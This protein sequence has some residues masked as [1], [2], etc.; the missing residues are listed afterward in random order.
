MAVRPI[1]SFCCGC[2]LAVGVWLIII[3]NTV[4]NIFYIY[5]AT[6]NIILR[7]PTMGAQQ[8]L[9]SQ[10]W[11]AAWC[12]LGIPFIF[13]G[14]WGL[15]CKQESTL[16]LYLYYLVLSFILDITFCITFFSTTD[17]CADMPVPLRQ[18]GMAFACGFMRLLSL[19]FILGMI[20]VLTYFIFVVWSYC[21]DL[22]VGNQG[23]G[24]PQLLEAAGE[25]R[26]K[27]RQAM[28]ATA[29]SM[30]GTYGGLGATNLQGMYN[31]FYTPG[32]E[33]ENARLFKGEFH[34]MQYPPPEKW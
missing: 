16:R 18:H 25:Y 1:A 5:T 29:F 22:K 20:I 12:L 23:A 8:G 15:W 28:P 19:G 9:V 17:I 11:N 34:E 13:A 2:P 6:S 32:L 3:C 31:E 14:I 30:A 10:T 27:R 4:Q 24:F 33:N 26:I 21:E 7:I